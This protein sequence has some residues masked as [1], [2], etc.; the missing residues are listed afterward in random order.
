MINTIN[1]LAPKGP[2]QA[3]RTFKVG[4]PPTFYRQASCAEVE[5]DDYLNGWTMIVGLQDHAV[6]H[7]VRTSGRPF[8][9]TVGPFSVT[10]DFEPGAPCRTPS[11][12][13]ILQRPE[14]YVVRAGDW[15]GNPSGFRREHKK[16]EFWVEEFGENQQKLAEIIQRG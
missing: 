5:C 10:F 2:I 13:R 7:T 1:R 11:A 4:A 12:H 15:R 16:P 14:L 3:Y 6:L 9:E 8:T